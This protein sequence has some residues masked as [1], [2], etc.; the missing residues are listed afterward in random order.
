M[1]LLIFLAL[2]VVVTTAWVWCAFNEVNYEW[3]SAG[4]RYHF[5][6]YNGA[7]WVSKKQYD[8]GVILLEIPFLWLDVGSVATG[9]VIFALSRRKRV[10]RGFPVVLTKKAE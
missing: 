9:A 5:H 8:V 2:F 6:N 4:W 7:I 3:E 1:L 10:E